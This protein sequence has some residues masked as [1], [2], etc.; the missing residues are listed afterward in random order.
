MELRKIFSSFFRMMLL[1]MNQNF[2]L[3][4]DRTTHLETPKL[5]L[6]PTLKPL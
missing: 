3:D 2:F 5:I 4:I 1:Y 6:I